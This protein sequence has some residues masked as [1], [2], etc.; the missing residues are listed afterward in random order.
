MW[1]AIAVSVLTLL[2]IILLLLPT[3]YNPDRQDGCSVTI[4][5]LGDLGRSPRMQYHALSIAKHG[6]TVQLVGY[7]GESVVSRSHL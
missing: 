2:V 6:A 1:T 4:V 7:L 5:V 3:R